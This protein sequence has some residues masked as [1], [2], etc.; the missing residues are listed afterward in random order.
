MS[1]YN[2]KNYTEQ[3]GEVT[4]I[5]GTVEID[6]TVRYKQ[7]ASIDGALMYGWMMQQTPENDSVAKLR[8]DFNSLLG[9]LKA[10]HIMVRNRFNLIFA[11]VN[12]TDEANADRQFNTS[13]ISS[14]TFF[15]NSNTIA[16]TLSAKPEDLKDFD[17]GE[18]GIHKWIGIG[19][20]DRAVTNILYDLQLNGEWFT[21]EDVA[22]A[23]A[24]G[25]GAGYF[26]LWLPVDLIVSG[27]YTG[28]TL[29]GSIFDPTFIKVNVA[30]TVDNI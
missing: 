19:I 18:E 30:F 20:G 10:S 24:V 3:G 22:E 14:T 21:E 13:K 28:F 26:V 1:E 6:G 4:H 25:L 12:D 5:G 29:S 17:A 2:A 11:G 8:S 7:T 23:T 9:M 27:E 16:I 15:S